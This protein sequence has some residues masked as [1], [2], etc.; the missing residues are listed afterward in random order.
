VIIERYLYRE[1]AATFLGVFGVLLLI[2]VSHRFVQYLAGAAAGEL[3]ADLLL[4]LLAV[5]VVANLVLILPLAYFVAVLLAFGRLYADSEITAMVAGGIGVGRFVVA[6]GVLSALFAGAGLVLSLVVT[7][8]A[9]RLGD[10]IE[11]RAEE[12]S[13]ITGIA[14]GRFKEFGGGERV[15]YAEEIS[16]ERDRLRHVFVHMKDLERPFLVLAESGYQMVDPDTGDRFMVMVNGHSYEGRPGAADLVVTRFREYGVRIEENPAAEDDRRINQVPTAELLA[17]TGAGA[18]AE[19]QWRL[20]MPLSMVL[21]GPLGLL[22]SRTSPRQG[23]FA[24]V[25]YGVLI[26]F[27][28]NNLL[29]VTRELVNRGELSPEVGLWP[30]HGA[31]ALVVAALFALQSGGHWLSAALVRRRLR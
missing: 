22:L 28:Y 18:A 9:H 19:F 7:P 11:N 23:R 29:G 31:V 27:V 1:V 8:T 17:M 21:L 15:F 3:S 10:T 6:L 14:G 26:Y 4:E 5:K 12:A 25:F 2:F 24:R 20:S 13:E 16:S 30:V